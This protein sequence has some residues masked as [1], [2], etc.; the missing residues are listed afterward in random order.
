MAS[1]FR[2]LVIS[3]SLHIEFRIPVH[4]IPISDL[5]MFIQHFTLIGFHWF[6]WLICNSSSFFLIPW[7]SRIVRAIVTNFRHSVLSLV[8]SVA[9]LRSLPH[10]FR[11]SPFH[12]RAPA[13]WRSPSTIPKHQRLQQ[14]ILIHPNS[15]NFLLRSM[16]ITVGL[17]FPDVLFDVL[18]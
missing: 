18:A 16:T 14:T 8:L 7:S 17:L 11:M 5:Q 15:W 9:P 12:L 3:I 10:H 4:G 1:N 13:G 2:T 6:H